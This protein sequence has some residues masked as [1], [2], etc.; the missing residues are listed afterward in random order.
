MPGLNDP[1]DVDVKITDTSTLTHS[2]DPRMSN[3]PMKIFSDIAQKV[4]LPYIAQQ[5]Q[6]VTR[7]NVR[8]DVYRLESL[9]SQTREARGFKTRCSCIIS[10]KISNNWKPLKT[11]GGL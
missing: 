6:V 8:W 2:L 3:A 4:F 1:Q 9:K 7:L 5:E 11:R 10:H